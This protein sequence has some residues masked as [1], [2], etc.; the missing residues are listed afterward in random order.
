MRK[1]KLLLTVLS[2]F[3][4]IGIF[5]SAAA[6]IGGKKPDTA[7][8]K[9]EN[10]IS[11][12]IALTLENTEF[13]ITK[14]SE[15]SKKY[16]L[17]MYLTASK[18]QGDFYAVIN[19]F[20]FSGIAYDNIVFTALTEK[21]ENK[22]IDEL[23]LTATDGIPDEYKWQIDITLNILGKGVYSPVVK[24]DFISGMSESTAMEKLIEIPVTITVE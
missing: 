21:A 16:T 6:V 4:L 8:G 19:G 22:T 14:N 7:S 2:V 17:T 15:E 1:H 13:T 11:D 18:T 12:R 10:L 24:I 5:V 9:T 23:T 20:E 3:V